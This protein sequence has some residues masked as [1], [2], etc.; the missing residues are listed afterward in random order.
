MS[1]WKRLRP[2]AAPDPLHPHCGFP[3]ARQGASRGTSPRR[4][5]LPARSSSRASPLP[6]SSS[7]APR[8][9]ARRASTPL[10][11]PGRTLRATM[12]SRRTRICACGISVARHSAELTTA[13][14]TWSRIWLIASSTSALRAPKSISICNMRRSA[15]C[16]PRATAVGGPRDMTA[17]V[18]WLPAPITS[19][20]QTLPP[21]SPSTSTITAPP[22]TAPAHSEPSS[23]S[24]CRLHSIPPAPPPSST[25]WLSCAWQGSSKSTKP[26]AAM[27]VLG[28]FLAGRLPSQTMTC[29]C[30]RLSALF[31]PPP[32]SY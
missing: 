15:A 21:H 9:T 2:A 20:S 31:D 25:L 3:C 19:D 17:N 6:A 4:A 27:P 11:R 12:A 30:A 13:P 24:D 18:R 5:A 16:A 32:H 28:S 10:T 22:H 1:M 23:S 8:E 26:K 29:E 14:G 7:S